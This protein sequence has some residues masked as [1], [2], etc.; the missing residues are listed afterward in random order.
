MND[1]FLKMQVF[2][3]AEM[4]ILRINLQTA[5]KQIILFAV[6]IVLVLL[7][8]AMLNVSMY[9]ALAEN[10]G[11]DMSALIV[12]AINGVLAFVIINIANR[13]KPGPEV[14]MAKE[15]RDLALKEM[16]SDVEKIGQNLKE[17]KG[18]VQRIRSGFG[19]LL[20]GGGGSIQG[21]FSLGPLLDLL[22][23]S[24]RKSKQ[25]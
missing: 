25:G 16:N 11:G 23:S 6:G 4:A 21:L 22:M 3:R 17:V 18:D 10:Y 1:F 19:G 24:L 14:D 13:T 12:S 7:A 8:V 9:I 20:S 15:I 2:S 5:A